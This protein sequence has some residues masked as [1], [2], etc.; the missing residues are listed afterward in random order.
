MLC[1][2]FK[3][4]FMHKCI[5]FLVFLVHTNPDFTYNIQNKNRILESLICKSILW[6]TLLF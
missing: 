3:I 5:L 6:C 1:L 4:F 2:Y